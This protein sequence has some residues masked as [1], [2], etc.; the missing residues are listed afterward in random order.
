M[1]HASHSVSALAQ[2]KELRLNTFVKSLVF[3]KFQPV[4]CYAQQLKLKTPLG[5][6]AKESHGCWAIGV[7]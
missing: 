7:G 2:A 1:A 6:A 3:L 4:I 5:L